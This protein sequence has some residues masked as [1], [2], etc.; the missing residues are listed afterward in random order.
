MKALLIASGLFSASLNV[1]LA[2]P[3]TLDF[4]GLA[5][6]SFPLS[7]Y[8]NTVIE[9]GFVLTTNASFGGFGTWAPGTIHYTGSNALF[10]NTQGAFTTITQQNADPFSIASI[11]LAFTDGG[12]N[13]IATS[14]VTFFGTKLNNTVVQQTFTVG[15]GFNPAMQ[16]FN[17]SNAFIGL[18][19]L[20]WQHPSNTL[21]FDN[22]VVDGAAVTVPAPTALAVLGFGLLGLR[23]RRRT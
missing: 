4:E 9:D 22:V 15:P 5:N 13:P 6:A 19:T 16:T 11:A 1:A 17:F 7:T 12:I 2:A 8:G 23:V 14:D 21:Q 3:V 18:A 10:A 20:M